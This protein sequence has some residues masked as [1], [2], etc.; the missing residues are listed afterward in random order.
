M[1]LPNSGHRE[2][3]KQ[4]TREKLIEAALRLFV[5]RGY[6]E[7]RIED[8]V[9]EVE[10]VPRTFFRYFSSK[11]D[12]L[13]GWY[14]EIR[15]E[16]KAALRARPRGEGV[17]SALVAMLLELAKAHRRD[18]RVAQVVQSLVK[19]SAE[20]RKRRAAWLY[21]FQRDSANG[22]ASR[23]PASAALAAEMVSAAV[24]AAFE[25]STT[26]WADE[27]A[28]RPLLHYWEPAA[29]KILRILGDIDERYVLR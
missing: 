21:D 6:E 8:I 9:A 10:I 4:R 13:F 24:H 19:T 18:D 17:A 15:E 22:L 23:L 3:K 11:D 14:D 27:G 29:T 5:E 12:A 2:R 1:P 25:V 7:T 28:R 20:I 26:Q 16:A